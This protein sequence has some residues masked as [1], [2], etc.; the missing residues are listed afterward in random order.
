[1]STGGRLMERGVV[2]A[3]IASFC[4]AFKRGSSC[5]SHCLWHRGERTTYI[6]ATQLP[7]TQTETS[8]SEPVL[9]D[10]QIL[11]MTGVLLGALLEEEL[12]QA[13][14]QMC[15]FVS[16]TH[17]VGSLRVLVPVGT[18][19]DCGSEAGI[20]KQD[21]VIADAIQSVV[22]LTQRKSVQLKLQ[23]HLASKHTQTHLLFKQS[24]PRLS[25][26]ISTV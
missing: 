25:A 14:L 5:S 17:S 24:L 11:F 21:T 6:L 10:K 20:W 15:V 16:K 1:M 8:V 18:P 7:L 12:V 4:L 19:G 3:R 26:F 13:Y 2:M 9:L 23:L 22:H